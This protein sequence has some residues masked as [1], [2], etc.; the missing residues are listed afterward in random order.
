VVVATALL[1]VLGASGAWLWWNYRPDHDQ[2]VR[3]THQVAAIAL[4]V[5]A[6]VLVVL[7]ILRR[8][9]A[10]ASGIVAALGVLATVGASYVTGR[11]LP[12]D[13]FALWA[14]IA[15]KDMQYGVAGTFDDRLKFLIVRSREVSIGTYQFWAISHVVLGVLV[16]LTIVLVWWRTK[17]D[18][19]PPAPTPEP[20]H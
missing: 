16:A 15:G 4:L 10:G 5:V 6:V 19:S 12:W 7:A 17:R 13:Q 18:V 14:V 2:W 3:T 1:G 8:A 11:L 9:G 20:A